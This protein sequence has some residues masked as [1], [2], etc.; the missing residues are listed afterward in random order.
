MSQLFLLCTMRCFCAA[1]LEPRR[2]GFI[3]L[4]CFATPQNFK[5]I[6]GRRIGAAGLL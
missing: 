2:C 5:R 6:V 3:V 4:Q 1:A